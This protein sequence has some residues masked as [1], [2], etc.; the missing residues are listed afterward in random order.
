MLNTEETNIR[1]HQ[2]YEWF[3]FY[4]IPQSGFAL[5]LTFPARGG[6]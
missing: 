2:L 5:G 6:A 3:G 1:A 4:R